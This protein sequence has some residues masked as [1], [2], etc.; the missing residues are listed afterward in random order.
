MLLGSGQNTLVDRRHD[1]TTISKRK[2]GPGRRHEVSAYVVAAQNAI[3]L[4]EEYIQRLHEFVH[5]GAWKA[6]TGDVADVMDLLR[7]QT[8]DVVG[9]IQDWQKYIGKPKPFVYKVFPNYLLTIPHSLDFLAEVPRFEDWIGFPVSRNP[10]LVPNGAQLLSAQ[11]QPLSLVPYRRPSEQSQQKH[12]AG[13]GQ[14]V[15]LAN[16]DAESINTVVQTMKTEE[17]LHGVIKHKGELIA[18]Q[19]ADKIRSAFKSHQNFLERRKSSSVK[20]FEKIMKLVGLKLFPAEWKWFKKNAAQTKCGDIRRG[21]IVHAKVLAMVENPITVR[22]GQTVSRTPDTT[23]NSK[24]LFHHAETTAT[25]SNPSQH[26]QTAVM[27]QMNGLPAIR[28][29]KLDRQPQFDVDEANKLHQLATKRKLRADNDVLRCRAR[30]QELRT[31]LTA[32]QE[33]SI[34]VVAAPHIAGTGVKAARKATRFRQRQL[35]ELTQEAESMLHAALH[36]QHTATTKLLQAAA[37]LR[38][39]KLHLKSSQQKK[40]RSLSRAA[41]FCA[42][43]FSLPVAFRIVLHSTIVTGCYGCVT[44]GKTKGIDHLFAKFPP[45]P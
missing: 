8:V 24:H 5:K 27:T 13:G 3:R 17:R 26:A 19:T 37:V 7:L 43:L 11:P 42:A 21:H 39:A 36:R 25:T 29:P 34:D 38:G 28:L 9:R 22:S 6:L 45:I 12:V 18:A 15:Y 40:V 32:V 16:V 35:H 10:L 1:K 44:K 20:E 33:G 41:F 2:R 30:L 14:Y 31:D 4:R 23:K